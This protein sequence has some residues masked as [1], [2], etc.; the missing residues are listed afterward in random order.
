MPRLGLATVEEKPLYFGLFSAFLCVKMAGER[1]P[2][3]IFARQL[4]R[5]PQTD[6]IATGQE[7]PA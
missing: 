7:V 4:L 3:Y 6:E 2:D 1:S 5:I